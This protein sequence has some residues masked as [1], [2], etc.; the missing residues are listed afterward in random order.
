MTL[1]TGHLGTVVSAVVLVVAGLDGP[2]S[3]D[4]GGVAAHFPRAAHTNIGGG[5]PLPAYLSLDDGVEQLVT[6]TSGRW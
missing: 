5:R 1:V 6:V 2:R 3:S 4:I